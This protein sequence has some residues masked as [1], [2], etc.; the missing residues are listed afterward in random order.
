MKIHAVTPKITFRNK[1]DEFLRKLRG[2]Y[3]CDAKT[4]CYA[5]KEFVEHP[6][7][8]DTSGKA[9]KVIETLMYRTCQI[10]NISC[11]D[12]IDTLKVIKYKHPHLEKLADECIDLLEYYNACKTW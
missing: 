4:K 7:L 11:I 8:K 3:V 9:Q 2:K 6:D 1:N 5:L 12:A 10:V